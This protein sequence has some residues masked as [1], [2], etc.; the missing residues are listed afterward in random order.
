M[1][2]ISMLGT[3]AHTKRVEPTFPLLF[4]ECFHFR[5]VCLDLNQ[6]L[7]FDVGLV[8]SSLNFWTFNFSNLMVCIVGQTFTGITSLPDLQTELTKRKV[9]IQLVQW[10]V[11]GCRCVLLAS[12]CSPLSELLYPQPSARG[13][14]AGVDVDLLM[15]TTPCFPVSL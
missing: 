3:S 4:H 11:H 1:L 13:N 15:E 6:F 7:K 9:H 14:V 12:F 2:R 10:Q 5:K 8:L